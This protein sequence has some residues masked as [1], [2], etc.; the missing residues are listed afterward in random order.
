M[1]GESEGTI[2]FFVYPA[3]HP[4]QGM[5]STNAGKMDLQELMVKQTTIDSLFNKGLLKEP[6]FIKMDVQGSELSILKGGRNCIIKCKPKIFLEAAEGWSNISDIYDYL[7]A[8]GYT[9]LY[10]TNRMTLEKVDNTSPG[11]GNWLA[12]PSTTS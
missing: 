6:D 5:G 2:S 7:T 4:N 1:L 9:I 10:I 12:L 3:D 8:L 11:K